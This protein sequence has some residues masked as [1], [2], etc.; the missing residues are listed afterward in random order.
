[1]IQIIKKLILNEFEMP[2]LK[3]KPNGAELHIRNNDDTDFSDVA[4]QEATTLNVTENGKITS[5]DT[6]SFDELKFDEIE[7]SNHVG[8]NVYR[9]SEI[10]YPQI[11]TTETRFFQSL[12]IY[13][14]VIYFEASGNYWG[15]SSSQNQ[16]QAGIVQESV[17][18]NTLNAPVC[19][20]GI[21]QYEGISSSVGE[22]LTINH[23]GTQVI[24]L[25]SVNN[26]TNLIRILGISL[27]GNLMYFHPRIYISNNSATVSSG[28]N[29]Q[30]Y[31]GPFDV[32]YTRNLINYITSGGDIDR[33]ASDNEIETRYGGLDMAVNTT[34]QNTSV[35][36][37]GNSLDIMQSYYVRL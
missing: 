22:L 14:P 12:P 25:S 5:N 15:T 8:G 4:I 36:T 2:G 18:N 27:G 26:T 3:A 31:N 20:H 30:T 19:V 7:Y 10:G 17:A 11:I 24:P 1:M 9:N 13:S 34:V 16:M 29:I 32:G 6:A 28:G 23:L 21:T 33:I 35:N 37:S